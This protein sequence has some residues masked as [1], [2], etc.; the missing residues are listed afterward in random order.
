MNVELTEAQWLHEQS[1]VSIEELAE[2]SGL[3]SALLRE[4]V[5][6]GALVPMN[7]ESAQ[8]TFTADCV[9]AVRTASRLREDFDLDAN[10]LSVAI[11]LIERIHALEA[12]LQQLR[13]QLPS[14]RIRR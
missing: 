14:L 8:W 4:L 1:E 9:I 7:V 6:Y 11:H 12:Q 2:L 10:A 13:S 5:D 3:S